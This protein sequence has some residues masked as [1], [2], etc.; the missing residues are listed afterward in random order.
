MHTVV[1]GGCA[2]AAG[3]NAGDTLMALAGRAVAGRTFEQVCDQ[4][5]RC[6]D[7]ITLTVVRVGIRRRGSRRGSMGS[8]DIVVRREAGASFGF[9]IVGPKEPYNEEEAGEAYAAVYVNYV[10]PESQAAE[11]GLRKGDRLRS[12][13]GRSVDG[14]L[15]QDIM[16]EMKGALELRLGVVSEMAMFQEAQRLFEERRNEGIELRLQR[17]EGGGGFGMTIAPRSGATGVFVKKVKSGGPAE[18]GGVAVGDVVV[19][20]DGKAALEQPVVTAA[21]R[22]AGDEIRLLVRRG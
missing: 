2:A 16:P 5:R 18:A 19:S 10:G 20:V 7:R 17:P 22:T 8:R 13:N 3:V 1:P 4:V 12:I 15:L 11:A 21:I 14:L 9:S 6:G